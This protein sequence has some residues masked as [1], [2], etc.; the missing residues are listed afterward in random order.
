LDYSHKRKIS[1][2]GAKLKRKDRKENF[3][4]SLR[5]IFLTLRLCVKR[6]QLRGAG[7]G[8]GFGEGLGV[9]SP[10]EGLGIGVGDGIGLGLPLGVGLALGVGL[11]L[12]EGSWFG[13]GLSAGTTAGFA[14]SVPVAAGVLRPRAT[15]FDVT[16][17]H[18][19]FAP[20]TGERVNL[21]PLFLP[22]SEITC[23]VAFASVPFTW[24]A[25]AV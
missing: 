4:S 6:S 23:G 14:T 2:K 13:I 7:L 16:N 19:S 17:V 3:E 21:L 24:I 18:F 22:R 15:F 8:L 12:G 25:T 9:G 11:G 10:G 20:A 5:L 1:R